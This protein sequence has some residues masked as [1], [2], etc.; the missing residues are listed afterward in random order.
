MDDLLRSSATELAAAI[1]CGSISAEEAV[2][3]HIR[4]IEGIND[5]LNAVVQLRAEEALDDA[6]AADAELARDNLLGPL[7]GVPMTIKDSIDTCGVKTTAGTLGRSNHV[8][9][10]DATVIERLRKAGA[11]LLG[12]TNTPE[13]TLGGETDNLVYGRTSNPYDLYCTCGGS[14][15]G[16]GAIVAACG[17]VF[18]VGSDTGG[19]IR[20]PA[21]YCGVAGL[22][23]TTGRVPLS[24]HIIGHDLG[25]LNRLT[26][27]GPLARRVEDLALI[28]PIIAG[29][30]G[31]DP[32]VIPMPLNDP[33]AIQLEGLRAAV[34]VDN[35]IATPD[36]AVGE[37][38]RGAA[39]ALSGAGVEIVEAWPRAATES[40]RIWQELLVAD[41]GAWIRR[42]LDEAGTDKPYPRIADRFF[43]AEPVSTPELTALLSDWDRLRGAML[44]F[45]ADYD[46]IICPAG[47]YPAP[48]HGQ[49][50]TMGDGHTYARIFNLTGW[51]AV[52]VRGGTSEHGLP[53]G[54]QIAAPPWREDV[55]LA[56]AAHL[57]E[58]LGGWQPPPL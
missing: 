42:L 52:A 19:S 3:A 50:N 45:M 21:H 36:P 15:G 2:Q 1:K 32:G 46:V 31:R 39:D 54:V 38:V 14:S 29:A 37:A 44:S 22:K 28:L 24:G 6:R 10:R 57:E 16:A 9:D 41:G 34:C 56:A 55:A 40:T 13:L 51:P 5:R 7:H 25:M 18:D 4:R 49:L 11:I 33:E 23:P 8:P 43:G 27:L 35:G 58:A 48:P 26:Q 12:K 53:I 17:A 30:D 47:A 20:L